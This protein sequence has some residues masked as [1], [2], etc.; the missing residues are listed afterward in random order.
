MVQELNLVPLKGPFHHAHARPV[1]RVTC[2]TL[3]AAIPGRKCSLPKSDPSLS[4][5]P[6]TDACI[7]CTLNDSG[8][9]GLHAHF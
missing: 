6:E 9:K 1:T 4:E 3:L 5:C 2:S 8:A 7:S